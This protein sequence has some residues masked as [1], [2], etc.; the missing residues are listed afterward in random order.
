MRTFAQV[1]ENNIVVNIALFEDGLTPV[2]LGWSGWYETA[3][4]I[5]KNVAGS[6]STFVPTADGYPLGLFH[7]PSPH[8][9]WVLDASYDWQPP[10]D[11]PYPEGFGEEG[12]T[13]WKWDD[14]MEDWFE[15][16]PT[17]EPE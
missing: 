9:G 8:N 16:S 2:D 15:L 7:G 13:A 1:D 17:P 3:D 5:R 6:G 12:G 10:A 14:V 4:N 11:K